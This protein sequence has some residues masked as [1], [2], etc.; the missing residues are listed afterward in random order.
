MSAS[1]HYSIFHHF[2]PC[3]PL[4]NPYT[5]NARQEEK[6][7]EMSNYS[8][9]DRILGC[10]VTAGM[11]DAIGAPSE[12]MSRDEIIEK[13][14]SRIETFLDGGDNEYALGNLVG[15]VTDDAS[16]MYEMA[17]AVVKADGNLT[18]QGAAEA[19]IAWSEGYPKYYP[20]NAGPTTSFVIKELKDGKDPLQ[21]GKVGRVYGRGT[22]NGA[23]M[24]VAAAGLIH[25]G[26]LPGALDT[27][28][29]MSSP[30]HATQHAY[31]GAAAIACG[32]AAALPESSDAL[33]VVK[34][35]VWG[36]KQGEQRGLENARAASGPSVAP[37]I[38]RAVKVAL[39]CD[40]MPEAEQAIERYVGNDGSIHTSVSAAVGLFAAAGGDPVK[41]I[42]GGANIGGD[43][44]TI[45]C[46]AGML[47]GAYKG[48]AALPSK[49]YDIFKPANPLLDFETV[50]RQLEVI[51]QRNLN[52]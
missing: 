37:I 34:A 10:L 36:A 21:V 13:Y 15:E 20:R 41:T 33:E 22:S 12:A 1:S 50:S 5:A 26:N 51:A 9:Y 40:S 17:K 31:A 27:A 8:L 6:E 25:P 3:G 29:I 42:L 44:D 47:A 7:A 52:G 43:S 11:G 4:H 28:I 23:A 32:I 38:L 45:A 48:F 14:G 46:I 24:R 2:I 30:S 16:Q 39:N 35:C 18:M 19:L 49:W